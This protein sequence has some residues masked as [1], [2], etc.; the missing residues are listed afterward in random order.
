MRR[1]KSAVGDAEL[2]EPARPAIG[3]AVGVM[4]VVVREMSVS[5]DGAGVVAVGRGLGPSFS[6][7]KARAQCVVSNRGGK[8]M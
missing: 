2:A 7:R 8:G 4:G 5:M 6:R 1:I 3:V